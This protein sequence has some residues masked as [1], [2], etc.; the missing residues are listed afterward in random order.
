MC[1]DLI[2]NSEY[3]S[4]VR[5]LSTQEY[6]SLKRSI[7]EN[8]Q[9]LPIIVNSRNVVLDGHHRLRIC[10]ELGIKPIISVKNFEDLEHEKLFVRR[11]QFTKTEL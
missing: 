10:R 5:Q 1:Q 11:V 8:G 6:E 9:Y 7:K 3:V 4:L 2:I